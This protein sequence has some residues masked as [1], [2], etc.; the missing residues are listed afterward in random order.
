[1]GKPNGKKGGTGGNPKG[2]PKERQVVT[3]NDIGVLNLNSVVQEGSQITERDN[4]TTATA[5]TEKK[6]RATSIPFET[7]YTNYMAV[8]AE[9]GSYKDLAGRL[10]MPIKLLYVRVNDLRDKA[11]KKH[12]KLPSLAGSTRLA[13]INLDRYFAEL[14]DLEDEVELKENTA[15]QSV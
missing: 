8:A 10:G 3:K 9:K 12:K 13:R 2:N 15:S 4:M 11:K 14:P 7:L 1:M 5:T 6:V